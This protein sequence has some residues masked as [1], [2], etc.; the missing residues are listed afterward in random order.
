MVQTTSGTECLILSQVLDA[1][2]GKLLAGVLDEVSEDGLIVVADQDDFAESRNLRKGFEAV[3]DNR[4]TGDF[5]KR[6]TNFRTFSDRN[7]PC[8]DA[9]GYTAGSENAPW[10]HQATE[11]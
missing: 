8:G 9:Q 1:Q 10:E 6:L 3:V 11:A 5:K 7:S 4:M 2:I